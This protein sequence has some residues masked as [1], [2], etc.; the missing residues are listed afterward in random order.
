MEDEDSLALYLLSDVYSK[1]GDGFDVFHSFETPEVQMN[2]I[3]ALREESEAYVQAIMVRNAEL[4]RS[5]SSGDLEQFHED[6]TELRR[7]EILSFGADRSFT[8]ACIHGHLHI[9]EYMLRRGYT[10]GS[11][12]KSPRDTILFEIITNAV[13]QRMEDEE[14]EEEEEE[15]EEGNSIG[16]VGVIDARR[17]K[18][19]ILSASNVIS[20]PRN[21]LTIV[22]SPKEVL[23]TMSANVLNCLQGLEDVFNS[24]LLNEK[25]PSP[26]PVP[27]FAVLKWLVERA[28][29]DVNIARLSDGYCPLHLASVTGSQDLVASLLISGADPNAV[30]NDNST[31]LSCAKLG[32]AEAEEDNSPIKSQFLRT[33]SLLQF[34]GAVEDW[35]DAL[36]SVKSQRSA[37]ISSSSSSSSSSSLS[38]LLH[39]LKNVKLSDFSHPSPHDKEDD[40]KEIEE[41]EV[42]ES[43]IGSGGVSRI[44]MVKEGSD[45]SNVSRAIGAVGTAK[46]VIQRFYEV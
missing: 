5:A 2:R 18:E 11:T 3:H 1:L 28:G 24:G 15:D 46:G 6:V 12:P 25:S 22:S 31:P 38:S 30:S 13:S 42:M 40:N 39:T 10:L 45:G 19:A 43:Q 14:E 9:A 23:D 7:E 33:L 37:T 8:A 36:A 27:P 35:R 26:F 20:E 34:K 44:K 17:H 21:N 4:F 32:L 41:E 16:K 29:V